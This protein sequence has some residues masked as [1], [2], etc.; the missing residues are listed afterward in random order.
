MAGLSDRV[1]WEHERDKTV[2]R[3]HMPFISAPLSDIEGEIDRERHNQRIKETKSEE[4]LCDDHCGEWRDEC[5]F[6]G[7]Q[8]FE[9]VSEASFAAG[10]LTCFPWGNLNC[11]INKS[12]VCAHIRVAW[13]PYWGHNTT[14]IWMRTGE[15]GGYYCLDLKGAMWSLWCQHYWGHKFENGSSLE[16]KRP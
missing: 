13:H 5:W 3:L 8:G 16:L 2:K 1:M 10:I 12:L 6:V 4:S 7:Q 15:L 14:V 9:A 11:W